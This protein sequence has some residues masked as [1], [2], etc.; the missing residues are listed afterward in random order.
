MKTIEDVC[1]A[2]KLIEAFH[3]AQKGCI[4]KES[5]QRYEC[6]LLLNT[7]D[8][9][10]SVREGHYSQREFYEFKINERGKCR[11]IKS[12]Y[13][14][15]RVLQRSLCDNIITPAIEPYLIYDNGASLKDKG[16]D[17]TRARLEH[18]LHSYFRENG[19][20]DGFVLLIDFS[21][22][23]DNIQHEELYEMLCDRVPDKEVRKLLKNILEGFKIDVSYLSDEDYQNCM[24]VVFNSLEYSKLDRSMMIGEKMM[25]KSVGIG[26]QISQSSGIYYPGRMD[27]YCKIV[28]GIKYYGRYMDDTYIIS[29]D[30]E[31]L[32]KLLNDITDICNDLG[33]FINKKKTQI[34]KLS[35]GFK[36]L[37]IHYIL[38]DSGKVLK[39]FD[40]GTFTREKRKIKKFRKKYESGEM[41]YED[42]VHSYLGWRGSVKKFKANT[43]TL[44]EVDRMFLELFPEYIEE[45]KK[46]RKIY[47][48]DSGRKRKSIK[49][50]PGF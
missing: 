49:N 35:H 20:N 38:T 40:S 13:I 42:I 25:P 44:H 31:Y 14:S 28:K 32:L 16:V 11:D 34:V 48:E 8:L 3:N 39:K 18:H 47:Y 36:F 23:F 2:N 43:R 29:S 7:Y 33:I 19:S 12:M 9:Q 10:K 17:F 1:N 22:Y 5:V 15:D 21:K 6:N 30:K 27:N 41:L 46:E 26:S 50:D 24:N 45:N 4:W 37:K